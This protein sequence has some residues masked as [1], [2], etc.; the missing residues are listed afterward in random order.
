MSL[1]GSPSIQATQ[2][3][4]SLATAGHQITPQRTKTQRNNPLWADIIS[5][6]SRILRSADNVMIGYVWYNEHD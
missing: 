6:T 4:P 1:L 3:S 5:S 2:D